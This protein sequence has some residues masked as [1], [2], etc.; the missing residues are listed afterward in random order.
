M[1]TAP[2]KSPSHHWNENE[3][4]E[5]EL[6][7]RIEMPALDYTRREDGSY[8]DDVQMLYVGWLQRA[9]KALDDTLGAQK[10]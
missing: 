2:V 10:E 3:R 5:F 6:A 8:N 1:S 4:K 9:R 7:M